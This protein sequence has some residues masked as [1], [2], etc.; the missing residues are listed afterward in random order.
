MRLA[1]IPA[2]AVFLA[3]FT[4]CVSTSSE[5]VS[6]RSLAF[7]VAAGV[8]FEHTE[9]PSGGGEFTEIAEDGSPSQ[10][11]VEMDE[12]DDLVVF[13]GV[14]DAGTYDFGI[15]LHHIWDGPTDVENWRVNIQAQ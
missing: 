4:G 8:A 11:S 9:D 15:V 12:N 5:S 10:L 14:L 13:S 2:L 7:V 1:F 6:E 3:A